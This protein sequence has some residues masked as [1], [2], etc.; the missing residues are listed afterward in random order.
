MTGHVIGL[1]ARNSSYPSDLL[2]VSVYFVI[3]K[4]LYS[5]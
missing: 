1:E 4:L 3:F 2:Q 5:V